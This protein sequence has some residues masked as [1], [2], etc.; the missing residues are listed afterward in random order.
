MLARLFDLPGARVNLRQRGFALIVTEHSQIV[1]LPAAAMDYRLEVVGLACFD[2][3][4][5]HTPVLGL[6]AEVVQAGFQRKKEVA[7]AEVDSLPLTVHR[8]LGLDP[9][10]TRGHDARVP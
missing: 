1:E 4:N 2:R 10:E 9:V 5:K 6:R 7:P 3:Q 8:Q